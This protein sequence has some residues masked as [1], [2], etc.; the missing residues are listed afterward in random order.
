MSIPVLPP[1]P[2]S[3]APWLSYGNALYTRVQSLIAAANLPVPPAASVMY[4]ATT[5][6]P[7]ARTDI[8]VIFTGPDPGGSALEGDFLIRG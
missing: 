7:T 6:R 3:G 4:S 8:T 5:A 2:A 1:E